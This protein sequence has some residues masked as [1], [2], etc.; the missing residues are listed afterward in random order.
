M[1]AAASPARSRAWAGQLTW[2]ANP[3]IVERLAELGALLNRPGESVRHS[4]PHCWRCKGP[5]LF[6]ATPQWFAAIDH[7]GLRERALA[8][9]DNTTWIPPWGKARIAGMIENRPDWTL[10]RQRIWGVPIPAFHCTGC[11]ETLADA[12]IMDHVADLFARSGADLWHTASAAELVPPGTTC[13]G[14]GAGAGQLEPEKDIV[15]V[16]FESGSSWLAITTEHPEVSPID[17]YLEGSDQHRGWFHSSLLIG[18]VVAGRAPYKDVLTHGF[19]LDQDGRPYSKSEIERARRQG[20]KVSYVAPDEIIEH[21]GAELFRLWVASTEFRSDI[22]YS[23]A[24]LAGLTEWYRKFRNTCRFILGNLDD[25]APD[26]HPLERQSLGELDRFALARLGDLVARVRGHYDAFEFHL[27][28][29]AVV[30]YVADL[31]ATY[32]DMVK[33][34]L[35]TE[36]AD[37]PVRRAAQAVLYTILSAL[38]RL[39][40]PILCFTAEDVWRH[41]PAGANRPASVH[42]AD[43]PGGRPMDESDPLARLFAALFEQREQ[44]TRCLEPFRAAGHRSTDARVLIRPRAANRALLGPRLELFRDLCIV[45]EVALAG[46]DVAAGAEPEITVEQAPGSRCERCWRW[47]R[48][49]AEPGGDLCRRCAGAVAAAAAARGPGPG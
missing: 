19:V 20:K 30:E 28:Y 14:C 7:A 41:L 49:M 22:P 6:R 23:Q 15:D 48:E 47:Y 25:F 37:A 44:V 32:L 46:D 1:T 45:S 13:P 33:D 35:Y 34:T 2:D 12:A 9:I 4:Y 39:V 24:L 26:H 29:R 18:I 40:A 11:G 27:A 38:T 43:L 16:W 36:A 42:L 10:S 8:E 5:V 31:S 3:A 17:L 21:H